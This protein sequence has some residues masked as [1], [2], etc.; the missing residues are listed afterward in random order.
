MGIV[1]FI[2]FP[3]KYMLYSQSFSEKELSQEAAEITVQKP[4]CHCFA[5]G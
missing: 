2:L 3:Y 5:V 4:W 1:V